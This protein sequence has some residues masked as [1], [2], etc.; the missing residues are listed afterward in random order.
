MRITPARV[1][2]MYFY[3]GDNMHTTFKKMRANHTNRRLEVA[4]FNRCLFEGR[5]YE[6]CFL[7]SSYVRAMLMGVTQ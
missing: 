2:T 3:K 4:A 1:I 6:K 5:K 7:T